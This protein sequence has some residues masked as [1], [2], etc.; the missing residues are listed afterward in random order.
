MMIF[1]IILAIIALIQFYLLYQVTNIPSDAV[2][3]LNYIEEELDIIGPW[4]I[5][6]QKILDAS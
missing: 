5:R 4:A 2:K 6:T 1:Y 3:R